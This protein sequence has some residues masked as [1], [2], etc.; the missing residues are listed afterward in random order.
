[1][2]SLFNI[3]R[4]KNP[5][6]PKDNR[7]L[8]QAAED[9]AIHD[10][11]KLVI[12]G[13]A[14]TIGLPLLLGLG[15]AL[16]FTLVIATTIFG[17]ASQ[18]PQFAQSVGLDSYFNNTPATATTPVTGTPINPEV[19]CANPDTFFSNNGVKTLG[20]TS[21]S[22]K[23]LLCQ[24][25]DALFAY[26][27]ID[28]YMTNKTIY[29][30]S[31][32]SSGCPGFADGCTGG[33]AIKLL[34]FDTSNKSDTHWTAIITHEFFHAL[35]NISDIQSGYQDPYSSDKSKCYEVT[36]RGYYIIKTYGKSF[37][38]GLSATDVRDESFAESGALYVTGKGT[39]GNFA[40]F[41]TDCPGNNTFWSE[42]LGDPSTSPTDGTLS[43][44]NFCTQGSTS[45]CGLQ[46]YS[47]YMSK[48]PTHVNFGDPSCEL[49]QG[50][51]IN[52][53]AVRNEILRQLQQTYPSKIKDYCRWSCIAFHE[54]GYNPNSFNSSSPRA[55]G[56]W[57]MFQME[58]NAC[59]TSD[60]KYQRTGNLDWK[61]QISRALSLEYNR[62]E[63]NGI[64]WNYWSTARNCVRG[65]FSPAEP[66]WN[67]SL[68]NPNCHDIGN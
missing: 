17:K 12:R 24:T 6:L 40:T 15:L 4:G 35:D 27:E 49:A 7:D 63:P 11:E 56:A 30:A 23:Q 47:N 55:K 36:N 51:G 26:P 34:N 62:L 38:D 59:Y 48:N 14:A 28:R 31:A 53:Q 21:Y 29:F 44:G 52:R 13:I 50:G 43:Q 65:K 37:A 10:S 54:G 5:H 3:R 22:K 20:I 64:P 1:M 41:R 42:T 45:N 58:P 8:V 39:D 68:S 57:G 67:D 32:D 33:N 19:D 66:D 9:K 16:I 60:F 46:Q 61:S 18:D 2:A 25:L